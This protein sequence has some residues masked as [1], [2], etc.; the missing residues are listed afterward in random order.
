MSSEQ[1]VLSRGDGSL[2]DHTRVSNGSGWKPALSVTVGKCAAFAYGPDHALN[3]GWKPV[4]LS[5]EE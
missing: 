4:P 1:L 3:A 5:N 2:L